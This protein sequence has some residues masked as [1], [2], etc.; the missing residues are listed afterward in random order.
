MVGREVGD[1]GSDDVW[2]CEADGARRG[3]TIDEDETFGVALEG[4]AG[5]D[6]VCEVLDGG[7]RDGER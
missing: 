7:A 5:E 1:I 4:A 2:V 3:L 6:E